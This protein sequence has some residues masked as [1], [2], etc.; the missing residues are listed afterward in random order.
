MIKFK[1]WP[2][3][4]GTIDVFS[5]VATGSDAIVL[6]RLATSYEGGLLAIAPN[7]RMVDEIEQRF[8][9]FANDF[10]I[11]CLPAWDCL[12]YDRAAPNYQIVCERLT[13]LNRLI[14]WHTQ[15]APKKP[16]IV[17]TTPNFITQKIVPRAFIKHHQIRINKGDEWNL[18]KL[19]R[20]LIE[21]GYLNASTV[22][23]RG[24]MVV[25][26]GLLDIFPSNCETPYRIDFFG[27]EI[28]NIY[29]LA[30]DNQLRG[31]ACEGFDILPAR[32][33]IL[34]DINCNR[35]KRLYRQTFSAG[36]K[37][38]VTQDPIF[39]MLGAQAHMYGLEHWMSFLH[40]RLE[41]LDDYFS[42]DAGFCLL[43]GSEE[44]LQ[45]HIES[46]GEYYQTR[47]DAIKIEEKTKT[48]K[49]KQQS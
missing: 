37:Q 47:I 2:K 21:L 32:E 13:G 33:F 49:R 48:L 46:I 31:E 14:D 45:A 35:F 29:H 11:I 40:D 15:K 19:C 39:E 6:A 27:D 34:N 24:E 18:D 4:P 42:D 25:R 9:F 8:A 3:N 36:T 16:L 10:E 44:V 22:R 43:E 30:E 38:D 5:S 12:P 17:L 1:N 7:D 20:Q 41:T 26:G 23:I 28:E